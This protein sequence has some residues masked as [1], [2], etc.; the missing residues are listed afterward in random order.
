MMI[1]KLLVIKT[2]AI[3]DVLMTTPAL[4]ALRQAYP[5]AE[6]SILIG[7]WSAP[8]LKGNPHITRCIE[9][10][11]EI[12]HKKKLFKIVKM[13][14]FL[15]RF[16][17]DAA[18]IF[19]PSPFIHLLTVFAGIKNR[20]GLSRKG[21]N[22]FLT[23]SIEENGAYDYYY[24]NNFLNVVR[25]MKSSP[26]QGEVNK[27][28]EINLEVFSKAS[29]NESVEKILINHQVS[30]TTKLILIAP[31]GSIN[32]KESISAR[33]WPYDYFAELIRMIRKEYSNFSI[34]LTG[35]GNDKETIDRIAQIQPQVID[36][37]GKTNIQELICLVG[38]SQCVICNDSSVLHIGIAQ[39]RPTIGIF[40]PTSIK[41]RV[42]SSQ[43]ENCIQ[44]KENCSPCYYFGIFSGC[45]KNA[46]CMRSIVPEMVFEKVKKVLEPV[47]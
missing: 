15:R 4:H 5:Q 22:R 10:D 26:A 18:V 6:I 31:G 3:G 44:S 45:N 41:S 29:D 2:H 25:L 9:F 46:S 1:K 33:V 12:L 32:P 42:P 7:K 38:I 47:S 19:H 36:L 16:R 40:G 28:F 20:F 39:N 34:I 14:L 37:C 11:D 35:G 17:F 13:I 30:D 24:P 23:L 43:I 27:D 21:W 8:V